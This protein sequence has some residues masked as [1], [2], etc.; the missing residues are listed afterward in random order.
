V[1]N[2]ERNQIV[3][4]FNIF[5]HLV[6]LKKLEIEDWNFSYSRSEPKNSFSG[7]LTALRD[8]Q[9]LESLNIKN[10]TQ[11]VGGL[12]DLPLDRLQEFSYDGTTYEGE[13]SPLDNTRFCQ[14]KLYQA[15]KRIEKIIAFYEEQLT[16]EREVHKE[17]LLG[18]DR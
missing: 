7:S 2:V 15:T 1:V 5:S 6:N 8:C 17:S 18:T 12:E 10:Q 13:L 16:T 4:D 14:I 11:L 9:N 3:A